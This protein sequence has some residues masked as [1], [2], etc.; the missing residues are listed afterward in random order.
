[1]WENLAITR[2]HLQ[3][4]VPERSDPILYLR[5]DQETDKKFF[6]DEDGKDMEVVEKLAMI[7]WLANSYKTFGCTLEIITDKSQEG[8]QFCS[9][10]GG[11]GGIM[12]YRVDFNAMDMDDLDLEVDLDDYMWCGRARACGRRRV[13][14]GAPLA[15]PLFRRAEELTEFRHTA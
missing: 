10:F 7:E 5:P 15:H 9:G 2:Y 11:I 12:R 1:M 3:S 14:R 6:V 8:S 4:N 13:L